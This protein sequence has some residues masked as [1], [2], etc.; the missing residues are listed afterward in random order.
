MRWCWKNKTTSSWWSTSDAQKAECRNVVSL[1]LH[2]SEQW[3]MVPVWIIYGE[4]CCQKWDLLEWSHPVNSKLGFGGESSSVHLNIATSGFLL[5][6]RQHICVLQK[7]GEALV[8]GI[9]STFHS[10]PVD[11]ECFICRNTDD[12]FKCR[13]YNCKYPPYKIHMWLYTPQHLQNLVFKNQT[14][15]FQLN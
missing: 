13:V 8:S 1:T 15:Y 12:I 4:C 6:R 10:F 11:L 3:R 5:S 9:K 14:A 2:S 7:R